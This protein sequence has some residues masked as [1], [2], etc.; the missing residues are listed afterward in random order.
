VTEKGKSHG[1]LRVIVPANQFDSSMDRLRAIGNLYGDTVTSHDLTQQVQEMAS[2]TNRLQQHQDRLSAML[3]DSKRLRGSDMLFVQDRL[4]RA[5]LDQ[6]LMGHRR[7]QMLGSATQSS[8]SVYL[9]EPGAIVQAP[10]VPKTFGEK[11][12]F[13][14]AAA[15]KSFSKFMAGV[16]LFFASVVVYGLI[17]V[18][19]AVVL[20]LIW[21][22]VWP[23]LRTVIL[24]PRK[25]QPPAPATPA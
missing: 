20:W 21:R 11:A 6:D 8:I 7:E 25:P 15:W 12:G 19:I 22:R 16:G 24:E 4:F 10:P 18:P 1:W 23:R 2:R 14:F 9:F 3:R 17:W 5:G 13:A